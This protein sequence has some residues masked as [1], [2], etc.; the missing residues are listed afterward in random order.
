MSR[1]DALN[2]LVFAA[3]LG[4]SAWGGTLSV[5]RGVPAPNR[6]PELHASLAPETLADGTRVLRD[7]SG[8]AVPLRSY[9]RI[10]SAT[11]IA[12]RVLAELCEPERIVAFTRHSAE[13]REGYRYRGKAQLT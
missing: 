5:G 10:A 9:E 6:G 1:L 11:M 7:A 4:L 8:V 13:G 12:D 3:A 2:A